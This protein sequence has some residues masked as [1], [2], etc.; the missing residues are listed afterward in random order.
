[1][2]ELKRDSQRALV[3]AVDRHGGRLSFGVNRG[4]PKEEV[5]ALA[6]AVLALVAL[7]SSMEIRK[8]IL[9]RAMRILWD[10]E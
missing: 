6:S 5:A 7:G 4:P 8:Q 10:S 3:K 9:G 1:M 2:A